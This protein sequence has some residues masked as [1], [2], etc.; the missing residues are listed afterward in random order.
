MTL[1][2]RW[3]SLRT[4]EP[5]LRIRAA[6]TKLGVSEVELL[7]TDCGTTVTRLNPDIEGILGRIG[8]LGYVMALTR[9]EEV[10]HE[11]KG[12]YKNGTFGKHASLFVGEDIDL[13]MFLSVWTK[14]Y[15]VES[16]ARGKTR[17]SLQFFD[18]HG[19]AVHK[20]YMT[21]RSDMDAFNK[22][23]D[24]YKAE[25]QGPEESTT[26]VAPSRPELPDAEID[27]EGFQKAWL[28]LKDTHD[29]FGMLRQFKVSRTQAL[30]LA[31]EGNWAVKVSNNALRETLNK[32]SATDTPIMVFVG[33]HGMIQ[34]H[35]G[36]AK[37]IFDHEQWLNVMD[38]EFN[39]HVNEPEITESWIVRKP[40]E[41]GIVTSLELF[42][43]KKDLICTLFGKRK[44]GIPELEEW[45]GLIAEV[46]SELKQ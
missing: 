3:D 17:Y 7:A 14:V 5:S 20:I 10:V 25:N 16:E 24:D 31:P 22:L 15:A 37:K 38:P 32:V 1:K 8:E 29:F 27:V 43:E 23:V 35:T 18:D 4:E 33:N 28:E 46:E 40:T 26:A 6:A 39:L 34:I 13:R 19:M 44:P 2:Q 21:D 9:N 42:N 12:E 41:D 45:R 30:R 36:L 11:R